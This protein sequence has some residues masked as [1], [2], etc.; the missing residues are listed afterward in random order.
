MGLDVFFH[1]C[2]RTD[3]DAFQKEMEEY[4]NTHST[5]SEESDDTAEHPHR[6]FNPEEI[7][8]FRKVNFLMTEFAYYGNCEY[9]E[10]TPEELTTLRGKCEEVL[11]IG[12]RHENE[13]GD[14]NEGEELTDS[15]REFVT[16]T[17]PTTSGFFFGSTDY[18]EYYFY[19][20][21]EVL[22]WVDGV[23]DGLSDDEVV[24]MYCW[25]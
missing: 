22:E 1:K 13:E 5:E 9:K 16:D 20:V 25:W 17:L 21:K 4:E 11:E 6:H 3:W 18:G 7:G 24:L 15:E 12:R 8:Y 14:W 2:K 19:D 10:I 23:L